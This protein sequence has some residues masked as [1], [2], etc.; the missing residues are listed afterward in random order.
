MAADEGAA[1]YTHRYGLVYQ[2]TTEDSIVGHLLSDHEATVYY[3]E[4]A[5]H[6]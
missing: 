6:Q 4:E 5:L 3:I 1:D 2:I